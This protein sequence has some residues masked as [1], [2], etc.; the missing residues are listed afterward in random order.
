MLKKLLLFAGMLM[1]FICAAQVDTSKIPI[2]M[3]NGIVYYEKSYELN[4]SLP[5]QVH[6]KNAVNW[7]KT[8]FSD[9]GGDIRITDEKSGEISGRGVLKI[10][11][12]P[13]GNYYWLRFDVDIALGDSTYTFKAYHV[14]EKPIEKGISNEFS[15][16]EYRWWDY[17]Q[18]HPWSPEDITLFKGLDSKMDTLMISLQHKLS[19]NYDT[20]QHK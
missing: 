17:R 19:L 16:I 4:A 3:K 18:G 13:N 1:P 14:Y 8:S 10:K 12:N 5:K 20:L 2:P 11:V 6:F 15:K 9:I 7:F